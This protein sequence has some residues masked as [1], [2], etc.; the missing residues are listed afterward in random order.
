MWQGR[1]IELPLIYLILLDG[2]AIATFVF[3]SAIM[4]VNQKLELT[5]TWWSS[6]RYSSA[7]PKASISEAWSITGIFICC[8]ASLATALSSAKCL[9]CPKTCQADHSSFAGSASGYGDVFQTK[10]V[11]VLFV[12]VCMDRNELHYDDQSQWEGFGVG[13]ERGEG[14][15]GGGVEGYVAAMLTCSPQ[16]HSDFQI[17]ATWTCNVWDS[18]H[19]IPF[20]PQ[21]AKHSIW[22]SC[23]LQLRT[24][25]KDINSEM[26]AKYSYRNAFGRVLAANT[27]ASCFS[28]ALSS[29]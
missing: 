3:N 2:S 19:G 13:R 14:E 21:A 11:S 28:P 7:W 22:D 15:R 18:Q 27:T 20:P 26:P 16:V 5:L 6:L 29:K 1:S 25:K 9:L 4:A 17:G 8:A 24:F 10:S 12:M 23:S